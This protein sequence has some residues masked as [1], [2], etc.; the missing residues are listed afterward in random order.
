MCSI[1]ASF[2]DFR[3]L[4]V[5][6][7]HICIPACISRDT[8]AVYDVTV[9]AAHA[10]GILRPVMEKLVRHQLTCDSWAAGS[11]PCWHSWGN[12]IC[13]CQS[14]TACCLSIRLAGTLPLNVII[15][16]RLAGTGLPST[17]GITCLAHPAC[18]FILLLESDAAVLRLPC[19]GLAGLR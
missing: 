3:K 1:K 12:V 6:H 4:D 17:W 11:N 15:I 7:D 13:I 19:C 2:L 10:F 16:I 9:N 8:L 18:F 14:K 5:R